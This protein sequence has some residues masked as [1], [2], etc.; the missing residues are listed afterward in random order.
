MTQ[1]I[2][3]ALESMNPADLVSLYNDYA[4]RNHY[5]PIFSMGALD[6]LIGERLP[7]EMLGMFDSKFSLSDDYFTVDGYGNYISGSGAALVWDEV[8][9]ATLAE[10]IA[11]NEHCIHCRIDVEDEE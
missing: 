4:D 9:A 8:D 1:K 10:W 2:I 11:E 5:E 6:E 3:N 7:S